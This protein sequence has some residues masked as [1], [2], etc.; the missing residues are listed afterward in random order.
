M[1]SGAVLTCA[2]TGF[3]LEP[4]ETD[5]DGG[6]GVQP[7]QITVNEHSRV[8]FSELTIFFRL[9]SECLLCRF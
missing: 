8:K 5:S 7:N 1:D 4:Q 9:R 6:A 2:F 3:S